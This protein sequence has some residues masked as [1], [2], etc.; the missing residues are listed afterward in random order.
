MTRQGSLVFC[1]A[2]ADR[3]YRRANEHRILREFVELLSLPNVASNREDIRKNVAHIISM[4]NARGL[5]E[6]V[7]LNIGLERGV[8]TPALFSVGVV[9]AVVTTVVATPLF[10]RFY[11]GGTPGRPPGRR[12]GPEPL[13][14]AKPVRREYAATAQ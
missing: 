6:L 1:G 5:M 11:T 14:E 8:I 3:E 4:M 9:M 12:D 10:D 7:V 2:D 13:V